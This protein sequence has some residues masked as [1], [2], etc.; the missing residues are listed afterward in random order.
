MG[1]YLRR[2]FHP[3]GDFIESGMSDTQL[4]E[5]VVPLAKAYAK[6]QQATA[7]I[8]QK[9]L[10]DPNEAGAASVDYLRMFA[11][12]ALGYMWCLMAKAAQEKI[13]AGEGNKDFYESK[14]I[15]ARFFFEKLL[16]EADS[17]FKTLMAGGSSLMELDAANF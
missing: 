15:T 2:F 6:L 17:R 7:T 5:F 9:G 3:V 8:A 13:A 14:I 16:P 4:Q 1:R 10:R 12:V 11:L